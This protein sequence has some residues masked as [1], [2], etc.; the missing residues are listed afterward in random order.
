MKNNCLSFVGVLVAA[1]ST[2][3]CSEKLDTGV[4]LSNEPLVRLTASVDTPQT[5]VGIE[6]AE[7]G[8][9]IRWHSNDAIFVQAINGTE[10]S[11]AKFEAVEGTENGAV[12]ATFEGKLNGVTLG[13]YA[14][15]P[16][17]SK[18]KFTGE[19]TLIYNLPSSYTYS[20]V[21]SAIFSTSSDY[22]STSANIPMIGKISGGSIS[23]K[24]L[25]GLVVIRIDEM[26]STSGTL[27]V[28][29]AQKLSGDFTVS[30]TS[31]SGAVI[32]TSSASTG[33][34]VK[35]IFSGATKGSAGVFYLPLATGS[36]NDLKIVFTYGSATNTIEYGELTVSRASITALPLYN[37]DGTIGKEKDGSKEINGH[38]FVDLG[39]SVL[40]AST[41]IGATSET[42]AG[43]YYA[44]GETSTKESY[45]S[46]NYRY[47]GGSK[48]SKYNQTDQKSV[49][50]D[51]D[52]A[53]IVNWGKSCRMPTKE[54]AE[55]LI[56]GCTWT[57]TTK[58]GVKGFVVTGKK[59][60]FTG[61]SIFLPLTGQ[62]QYQ[63]GNYGESACYW[64]R[65]VASYVGYYYIKLAY[66]QYSVT[67]A[68]LKST[69][70]TNRVI[71]NPVRAV[72][73]K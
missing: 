15:Y 4:E 49:L 56:S 9:L 55:E 14:A 31:V 19:K 24:H 52:D 30:D 51:G 59:E 13:N 63:V 72:A 11:G 1:F 67:T 47:D 44:W 69:D 23:F 43:G 38:Y 57:K 28:S 65:T 2:F 62:Y 22:R 48:P 39:L 26:P 29:A 70:W 27:T 7:D 54:E 16:Y 41:N 10:Y 60:G 6:K 8:A 73:E 21:E 71:G 3:S 36:Y 50:D 64:T 37:N 66:D 33:N 35:F 32:E 34:S 40:W 18:H 58:N 68:C 61:N 25:G 20:K 17:N 45:S 12:Y 42:E 5:R 46:K 53:A